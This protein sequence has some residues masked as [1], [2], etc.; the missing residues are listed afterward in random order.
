MYASLP[1]ASNILYPAPYLPT[2]QVSAWLYLPDCAGF[3]GDPLG[4]SLWI[5]RAFCTSHL[6]DCTV[7]ALIST[8]KRW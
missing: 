2:C 4:A 5:L 8:P 1:S 6:Y 7:Y 3:P